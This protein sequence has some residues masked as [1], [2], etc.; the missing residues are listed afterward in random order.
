MTP[1]KASFIPLYYN[2][3][4]RE[5]TIEKM[6][7]DEKS[8][9]L[10]KCIER[11]NE[12]EVFIMEKK[13]KDLISILLLVVG[14]IFI[15]VA[16][17]IFVTTAWKYLP[18][19]AKQLA[20]LVV[21][22]G[23]FGG[24]Y[25][26]GKNEKLGWISETLFHVGN[27]FV[28]FFVIA[29][30]GGMVENGTEGNAFKVMTASGTMA[31]ICGVKQVFKKSAFDFATLSLLVDAVLIGGC[32]AFDAT[33]NTFMYLLAGWVLVLVLLDVCQVRKGNKGGYALCVGI[34]YLVH[35]VLYFGLTGLASL[36]ILESY[37]K[38]ALVWDGIIWL[39]VAVA[40]STISYM[41]RKDVAIRVVNSLV[42]VWFIFV[43]AN[44]ICN[45]ASENGNFS[46]SFMI[47]V[48]L[49]SCLM[50]WL[51][52]VELISVVVAAAIV[53]PYGQLLSYWLDAFIGLFE[54]IDSTWS[55]A[56]DPYSI[57]IGAAMFAL[58]IV[59]YGCEDM[60]IQWK[61]SK[62]LKFAGWQMVTGGVMWLAS[63]VTSV[64]GMTFFLLVALDMMMVSML[65]QN[66]VAKRVFQTFA[67]FSL[68]FAVGCQPLVD[69][70]NNFIVEWVC[71]LM[72]MGIVL[73]RIIWYDNREALSMFYYIAT[74][75]L[76]G[77]LLLSNLASGGLGNVMILG[78]T[79]IVILVAAAMQN[80]KKYVVASSVT[81]ILLVLY[82]TR[83][84]WLSIAWW[85]YLFA[86]GVGLVL[87][88]VKKAKE[89]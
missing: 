27:A 61:E 31:M 14:V 56:Y 50:V 89:A 53:I 7:S 86:A 21:A 28:G 41:V 29:V 44:G 64:W 88:A 63:K 81:L 62:I 46:V 16:G 1:N 36:S 18:V 74:C 54:G 83:E 4:N 48:L 38:A 33:I 39:G 11:E 20:L 82:L 25:L 66:K 76:L 2:H 45:I 77:V 49:T 9:K 23:M 72:A 13:Q 80:N 84:F 69:I 71:F 60:A 3:S 26:L 59:K 65:F 52:R 43:T 35:A 73:F 42:T 68:V 5:E 24:S 8:C 85:V 40:I 34:T 19:F 75:V 17:G 87:L 58:Y 10:T 79:G 67:M 47:T 15:L 51:R 30:M 12:K 57:V 6:V 32:I 70:P 78:M 55:T 37:V 22:G